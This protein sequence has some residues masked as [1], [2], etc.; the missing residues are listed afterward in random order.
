MKKIC[1][2]C[3]LC[4]GVALSSPLVGHSFITKCEA[5]KNCVEMTALP[6]HIEIPRSILSQGSSSNSTSVSGT[7]SVTTT[8]TQLE[9]SPSA[10]APSSQT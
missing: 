2:V 5:H 9:I 7:F 4:F 8:T 1:I 3:G 6:E 10:S